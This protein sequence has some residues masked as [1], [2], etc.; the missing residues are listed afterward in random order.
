M[1]KLQIKRLVTY[2]VLSFGFAL[3][4]EAIAIL[5]QVVQKAPVASADQFR[6]VGLCLVATLAIHANLVAA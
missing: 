4:E 5:Q 6:F 3:L 2:A 1:R